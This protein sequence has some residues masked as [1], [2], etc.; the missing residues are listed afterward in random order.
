MAGV[1]VVSRSGLRLTLR[2]GPQTQQPLQVEARSVV[3]RIQLERPSIAARRTDVVETQ[4]VG[5]AHQVADIRV[6]RPTT[7]RRSKGD[8]RP[9]GV[10]RGDQATAELGGDQRRSLAVGERVAQQRNRFV[11]P[12][13]SAQ[14]ERVEHESRAVRARRA[15]KPTARAFRPRP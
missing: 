4:A 3:P 13:L 5:D 14:L 1:R 6:A 9:I 7:A 15:Q 12:I 8:E 11:F 10:T 2:D